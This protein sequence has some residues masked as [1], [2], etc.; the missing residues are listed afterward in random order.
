MAKSLK[1]EYPSGYVVSESVV[2]DFI[3]GVGVHDIGAVA[4]RFQIVADLTSNAFE[5]KI[6]KLDQSRLRLIEQVSR[7][8]DSAQFR[9]IMRAINAGVRQGR[10]GINAAHLTASRAVELAFRWTRDYSSALT[11]YK[12]ELSRQRL[13]LLDPPSIAS[14][15]TSGAR[16][17]RRAMNPNVVDRNEAEWH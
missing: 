9:R 5:D 1:R 14:K 12:Q 2:R 17:Q 10:L 3:E 16:S 7:E 11:S 6:D 8:D 15:A 13:R 4:A